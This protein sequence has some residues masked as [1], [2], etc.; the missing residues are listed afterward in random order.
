MVATCCSLCLCIFRDLRYVAM[1]FT[2]A[3]RVVLAS[4]LN[5]QTKDF[6]SDNAR[7]FAETEDGCAPK[8][9]VGMV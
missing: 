2:D 5:V 3:C 6:C 4:P 1:E 9:E 8:N 7:S